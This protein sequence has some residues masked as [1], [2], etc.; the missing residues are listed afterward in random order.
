VLLTLHSQVIEFTGNSINF[1]RIGRNVSLYQHVKK[2]LLP[3]PAPCVAS[4]EPPAVLTGDPY[5]FGNDRLLEPDFDV[6][7]IFQ[8]FDPGLVGVFGFLLKHRRSNVFLNLL[9]RTILRRL[10]FVNPDDMHPQG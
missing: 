8:V 4:C 5:L 6:A 7:L 2:L 10:S 3:L 1:E 9:K